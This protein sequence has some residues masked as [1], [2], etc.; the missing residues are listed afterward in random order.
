MLPFKGWIDFGGN[1]NP[2]WFSDPLNNE[3]LWGTP[4]DGT[5]INFFLNDGVTSASDET[6]S[7]MPGEALNYM[8]DFY[9]NDG[10][11][12]LKKRNN[13][14][15]GRVRYNFI[16]AQISKVAGGYTPFDWFEPGYANLLAINLMML[17][18]ASIYSSMQG[19]FLIPA[20]FY[21]DTI[22]NYDTQAQK[23]SHTFSEYVTVV[24]QVAE[25]VAGTCLSNPHFQLM[26]SQ[27]YTP[28]VDFGGP[29]ELNPYGLWKYFL[30]Q[31][32]DTFGEFQQNSLKAQV[33][34][35][36]CVPK[37]SPA[38]C[39]VIITDTTSYGCKTVSCLETAI[40]KTNGTSGA[41]YRGGSAYFDTVCSFGDAL[42]ITATPPDFDPYAPL[43]NY[44]TPSEFSLS[45]KNMVRRGVDWAWIYNDTY[46]FFSEDT[47]LPQDYIDS[48]FELREELGMI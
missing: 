25:Y 31:L 3:E 15:W 6:L 8:S 12:Q 48:L 37:L 21:P 11:K 4:V 44:F 17:G 40:K 34:K 16:K 7:L 33:C 13:L 28:Y 32:I 46:S 20:P 36:E 27:G 45:L 9:Y 14:G 10:I 30:D 23:G 39:K 47:P 24:K 41:A 42:W 38:R 35:G 43:M 5:V 18:K 2:S 29:D 19:M 26:V 1:Q 22:W